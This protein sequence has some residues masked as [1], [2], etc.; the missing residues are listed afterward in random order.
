MNV[1]TLGYWK[2]RP[3]LEAI[4]E[5]AA[6]TKKQTTGDRPAADQHSIWGRPRRI[7]TFVVLDETH[8]AIPGKSLKDVL[9][10]WLPRLAVCPLTARSPSSQ[11]PGCPVARLAKWV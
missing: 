10:D 8:L 2:V 9:E 6:S 11:L 7:A 4:Q 1:V 5:F 3:F